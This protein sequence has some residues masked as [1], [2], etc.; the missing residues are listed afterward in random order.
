LCTE[1]S[2]NIS[3]HLCQNANNEIAYESLDARK[4]RAKE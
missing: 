2:R 4:F 3:S 1:P